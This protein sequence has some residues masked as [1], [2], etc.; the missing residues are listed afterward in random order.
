MKT[1]FHWKSF[2]ADV[3]SESVGV[4]LPCIGSETEFWPHMQGMGIRTHTLFSVETGALAQ[5]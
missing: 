2:G 1:F 3:I 5:G 4:F